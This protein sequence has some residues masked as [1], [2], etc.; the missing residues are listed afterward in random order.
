MYLL[1]TYSV[2]GTIPG[3]EQ[4]R[5]N[6]PSVWQLY[7]GKKTDITEKMNKCMSAHEKHHGG[8]R[9]FR[10]GGKEGLSKGMAS[11]RPREVKKTKWLLGKSIPG[12]GESMCKGSGVSV[13]GLGDKKKD[14]V[15][16]GESSGHGGGRNFQG[17]ILKSLRA[18]VKTWIPR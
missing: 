14:R 8:E 11:E 18:T 5:Q 1:N 3:T 17:Q 16:Q 9:Y 7:A 10:C 12:R 2:P 15:I 13:V 6:R 4:D